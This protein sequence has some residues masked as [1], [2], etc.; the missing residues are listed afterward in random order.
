[1]QKGS[2]KKGF[3]SSG[4]TLLNLALSGKVDGGWALGHM[5][6][7]IGDSNTGKSLLAA[8]ALAEAAQCDR[9]DSYALNYRDKEGAFD[10]DV[11]HMFGAQ[12]S[13]RFNLISDDDNLIETWRDDLI[14]MGRAGKPFIE[15]LDSFDALS[16]KD[17]EK[18]VAK[19]AKG[20]GE[21]GY[22]TDRAKTNSQ[23]MRM[24]TKDL[25]ALNALLIVVSQTREVI[26]TSSFL[27]RGGPKQRFSG[28]KALKFYGHQRVWLALEATIKDGRTPIGSVVRAFVER[29]RVTGNQRTVEFP[30]YAGYGIDDVG[31]MID[32]LTE[33]NEGTEKSP[34]IVGIWKKKQGGVIDAEDLDFSGTR[35]ELITYIEDGA[36][37]KDVKFLCQEYWDILEK[38]HT[39]ERKPRYE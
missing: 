14:A 37:E 6:H 35:A 26:E 19:E 18:S 20:K 21:G 13:K 25:E 15:V 27:A 10:F 2:E 23:I 16:S 8:T 7:I 9:F 36:L 29:T 22:G 31:S 30:V 12:L 32:W 3:L 1:M 28:G 34:V 4:S 33:H 17:E 38:Q 39:P 24:I 5:I 11:T